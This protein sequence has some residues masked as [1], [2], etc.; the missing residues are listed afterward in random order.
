MTFILMEDYLPLDDLRKD[1]RSVL[2]TTSVGF[3]EWAPTSSTQQGCPPKTLRHQ[4]T[5]TLSKLRV[6]LAHERK[7]A[8]RNPVS[9]TKIV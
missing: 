7:R 4:H 6:F 2:V 5:L 3:T 1:E 8:I 9:S